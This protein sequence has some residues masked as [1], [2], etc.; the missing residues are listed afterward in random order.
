MARAQVSQAVLVQGSAAR[1]TFESNFKQDV[2]S[3]LNTTTSSV[4]II[5]IQRHTTTN[6]AAGRRQLQASTV[7]IKVTFRLLSATM[8]GASDMLD[9]IKK[10]LNDPNSQLLAGVTTSAATPGTPVSDTGGLVKATSPA[11]PVPVWLG[12]GAAGLVIAVV[13]ALLLKYCTRKDKISAG[14]LEETDPTS[15]PSPGFEDQY[16]EESNIGDS[17]SAGSGN[18]ASSELSNFINDWERED[19]ILSHVTT[20]PPVCRAPS[21]SGEGVIVILYY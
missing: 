6:Q 5:S 4:V 3:A 17:T 8:L 20:V 14:K 16:R 7:S 19:S 2:A 1:K 12:Y 10:Q 9:N 21:V 15:K 13:L 11:N 18:T